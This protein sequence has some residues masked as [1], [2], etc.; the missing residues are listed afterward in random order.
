MT[1]LQSIR[2][3]TVDKL[4]HVL[5]NHPSET[6][7]TRVQRAVAESIAHDLDDVPYAQA[8][9]RD[10]HAV[11]YAVGQRVVEVIELMISTE[12]PDDTSIVAM[13]LSEVLDLH[14]RKQVEMLGRLFLPETT[15]TA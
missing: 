2:E 11:A 4:H 9:A 10:E 5:S 8:L 13:L 14:E 7:Y 1:D 15:P 6:W 12:L 3:F